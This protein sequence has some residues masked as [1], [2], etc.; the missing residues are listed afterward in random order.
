[1]FFIRFY[2]SEVSFS[3]F[4]LDL[5]PEATVESKEREILLQTPPPQAEVIK[6]KH[7]FGFYM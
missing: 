3:S 4:F 7:L 2:V 1:M 5:Q 6:L